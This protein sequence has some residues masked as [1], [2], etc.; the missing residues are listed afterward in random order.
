[1]RGLR[2]RLAVT[3]VGLV[4]VTVVALGVGTYAFVDA[5]LRDRLLADAQQQASFNLSVLVPDRLPMGADRAAFEASGLVEAFR[6]RGNVETIVDFGDG[7]PYVS[8]AS[9][10]GALAP[11][12]AELGATVS[13]GYLA[14]GWQALAGRS[15]LVV[16][17]RP[18]VGPDAI[19]FVFPA[20]PIEGA[21][22]QLRLG[23][24]IGGLVAVA[25]ALAAS[26]WIATR[27]LRPVRAASRAAERLASGD[28]AARVPQG[29]ADEFGR[30]AAD[31]NRMAA[32]LEATVSSLERAQAQNRRFVADVSHELRT[33]LAALV[34]EASLIEG[35]LSDLAPDARRAAELLVT[36]VRR[37]RVLVDDLME[38]SRFD[39][40]VEVA[41]TRPVDLARVIRT[42][43]AARHPSASVVTP[44]EP[45][46]VASDPR[47][48]DRIL[49]NLLD[50]AR[51][52][53]PGSPVEVTLARVDG[54]IT[55]EVA[56][57]GPGIPAELVPRLFE[58]FFKAEPS[59]S[60][61][62]SG[63]GLAIAAEHAALLGGALGAEPRPGGG[64]VVTLRLPV[65]PVT[66]PLPAGD[67]PVTGEGDARSV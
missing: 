1:M 54:E 16:G 25:L 21:L 34:A 9:L 59:R 63:L 52:H 18:S 11:V 4:A 40:A 37:L 53:A 27:I 58:R 20:D 29:G 28:L 36:D 45:V 13:K 65:T 56:D 6:L 19:Y 5:S 14:Y 35:S 12:S 43:V 26:G 31:F 42:A 23:L 51:D 30:W 62:G 38:L 39:A 3:I 24:T 22:G 33:P 32:T 67:G 50:N 48:L 2:S 7:D 10:A 8:T 60:V 46:V 61:G 55:I 66:E 47:R 49:G 44:P 17:G 41:E 64:L 15:V 57:R